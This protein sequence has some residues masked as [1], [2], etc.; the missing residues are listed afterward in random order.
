M[1]RTDLVP[2]H[3]HLQPGEQHAIRS[4]RCSPVLRHRPRERLADRVGSVARQTRRE[5]AGR[6]ERRDLVVHAGIAEEGARMRGAA[7]FGDPLYGAAKN[8]EYGNALR[9]ESC[10]GRDQKFS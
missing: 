1:P 6:Q 4:T 3:R 10:A 5:R 8:C 7:R 9:A 2:E